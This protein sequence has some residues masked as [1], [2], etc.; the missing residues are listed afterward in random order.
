ML[1]FFSACTTQPLIVRDNNGLT[2]PANKPFARSYIK[3]KIALLTLFNEAPIG[4]DDLAIHVTEEFRRNIAKTKDY[5]VDPISENIF[6]SSK[7]VYAGGGSKLVQMSRKAKMAGLNLVLYGRILEARVRQKADEIG[8]MRSTKSYAEVKL[9]CVF[10]M[11]ILIKNYFL[12]CKT[13]LSMT[14]HFDFS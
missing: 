1:F 2:Y 12:M 3:K 5:I 10:M 7:E 8:V 4:G 9:N 14:T 11:F 13:L 6:G